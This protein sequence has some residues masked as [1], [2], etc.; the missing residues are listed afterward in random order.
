MI[1]YSFNND[2]SQISYTIMILLIHYCEELFLQ[3]VGNALL[4]KDSLNYPNHIKESVS[5]NSNY[6][7]LL[8]SNFP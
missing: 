3:E 2:S 5:P 1:T 4:S 8:S 6:N 7:P